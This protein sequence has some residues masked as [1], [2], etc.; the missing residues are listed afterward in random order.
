[1]SDILLDTFNHHLNDFH[2]KFCRAFDSFNLTLKGFLLCFFKFLDFLTAFAQT[3]SFFAFKPVGVFGLLRILGEAKVLTHL[4]LSSQIGDCLQTVDEVGS[5]PT[6][7]ILQQLGNF[8]LAFSH[9]LEPLV[10]SLAGDLLS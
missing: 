10:I 7:E 9:R 3:A 4:K 5:V 6:K 1:M 2:S 8:I